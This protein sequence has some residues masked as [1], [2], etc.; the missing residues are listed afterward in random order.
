MQSTSRDWLTLPD[1]EITYVSKTRI[2]I[3]TF[4]VM[5]RGIFSSAENSAGARGH[6]FHLGQETSL[7]ADVSHLKV[8][9]SG[10][11]FTAQS[12]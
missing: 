7:L 11:V 4:A 3:V 5:W 2:A 12:Q 8:T 10:L 9:S 6:D 1:Q